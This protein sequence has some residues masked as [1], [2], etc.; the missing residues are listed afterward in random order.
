MWDK[1]ESISVY[2]AAAHCA[3]HRMR[4]WLARSVFAIIGVWLKGLRKAARTIRQS[5]SYSGFEPLTSLIRRSSDYLSA[6]TLVFNKNEFK[7][8]LCVFSGNWRRVNW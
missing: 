1:P 5:L 7:Q 2:L 3:Y 6:L 8:K 4:G